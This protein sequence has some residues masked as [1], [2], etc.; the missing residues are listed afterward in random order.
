VFSDQVAASSTPIV[1]RSEIEDAVLMHEL[2]HV[3]GLVDLARNTGRA[4]PEH[5]GH[6][7]N[8]RSVMY[9]AVES[10]L[11]GQVLTGSPPKDFDQQDLA[12]LRA[13]RE[14]A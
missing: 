9:W 1:S 7:K 14:G 5:P 4:D 8:Q 11:I 13:L 12:D 6:S 3:L 10:S 2:G